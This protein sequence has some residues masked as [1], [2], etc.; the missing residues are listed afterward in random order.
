M[1]EK[2][3]NIDYGAAAEASDKVRLTLWLKPEIRD[4]LKRRAKAAG[5]SASAYISVMM[6]ERA[7]K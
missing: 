7:E 2:T 3:R 1:A 6:N 4:E 5:V